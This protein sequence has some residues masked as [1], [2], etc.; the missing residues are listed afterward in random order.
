[1]AFLNNKVFSVN[2]LQLREFGFDMSRVS[3]KTALNPELSL[4]TIEAL[5]R[6]SPEQQEY[7]D[8]RFGLSTGNE[9]ESL[10]QIAK[11]PGRYDFFKKLEEEALRSLYTNTLGKKG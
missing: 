3:L 9:G 10:Q 5:S 7:L 6:L 8:R 4:E 2:R 1:M 11:A